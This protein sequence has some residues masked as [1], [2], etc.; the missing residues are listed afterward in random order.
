MTNRIV[1]DRT[2]N[3]WTYNLDYVAEAV[4]RF[5][6]SAIMSSLEM[7]E[8]L[9]VINSAH[10]DYCFTKTQVSRRMGKRMEGHDKKLFID[11]EYWSV[12]PNTSSKRVTA[13]TIFGNSRF[14]NTLRVSQSPQQRLLKG[15]VGWKE[16]AMKH[17]VHPSDVVENR[18]TGRFETFGY[19]DMDFVKWQRM[20]IP[21]GES[22][23]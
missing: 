14:F 3:H 2:G 18:I 9:H 16:V 11:R 7:Y 5:E 19:P 23:A 17:L 10:D 21:T 22:N 12:K 1:T 6:E 8:W 4:M 20:R 15:V 13:H